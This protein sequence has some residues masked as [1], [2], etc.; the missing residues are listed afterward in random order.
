[1]YPC[2]LV[3]NAAVPVKESVIHLGHKISSDLS[4]RHMDNIIANFYKQCNLFLSRLGKIASLVK[5]QLFIT[6]CCSF[7]HY[8]ILKI[9][10]LCW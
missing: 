5:S 9:L 4:E 3:N 8:V 7:Y 6:Y 2:V 10:N 1:M